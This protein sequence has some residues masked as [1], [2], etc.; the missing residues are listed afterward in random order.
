MNTHMANI[1][2]LSGLF[3]TNEAGATKNVLARIAA[4][5][6]ARLTTLG[7]LPRQHREAAE[8]ARFSDRELSDIGLTRSDLDNI[9]SPQFAADYNKG[10]NS[11]IFLTRA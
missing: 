4:W 2:S 3:G 8:L 10:R 1:S 6:S 7:D 11:A 5:F 9:Q